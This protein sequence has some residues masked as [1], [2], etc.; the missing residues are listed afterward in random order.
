MVKLNCKRCGRELWSFEKCFCKEQK[1]QLCG[2]DSWYHL[3]LACKTLTRW[4]QLKRY[5]NKF[6]NGEIVRRQGILNLVGHGFETTV[7]SYINSLRKVNI[8][9]RIKPGR[10]LKNNDIPKSLTV[11]LLRELA[12][13]GW[14][15]WFMNMDLIDELHNKGNDNGK[16]E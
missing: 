1:C 12:Y 3:C 15:S 5:I 4:D 7:D 13:G 10:Y 2:L 14:K 6:N 11:T 8:L 16:K 9:E